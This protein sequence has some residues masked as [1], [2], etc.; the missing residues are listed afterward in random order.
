VRHLAENLGEI[1]RNLEYERD[2]PNARPQRQAEI[3][4]RLALVKNVAGEGDFAAIM[5]QLR[6]GTTT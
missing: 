1:I 5:E 2:Q 4:E 3:A 6:A